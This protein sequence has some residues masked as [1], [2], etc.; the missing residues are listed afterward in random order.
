MPVLFVSHGA[1]T[2]AA[3]PEKGAAFRRLGAELPTPR[4]VLAISAHWERTPAATGTTQ[5]GHLLHDFAGF[6]RALYAL[7]Y[8]APGA[9]SLAA[10]VQALLGVTHDEA[11]PWDHGVWVPLL[12][13]LPLADVP[14]LQLALPSRSSPEDLFALGVRLAPLR[15]DGVLVLA[16]GGMVHDF[17]SI[18]R[19]DTTPPPTFALEFET[20][21]RETLTARDWPELLRFASRAPAFRRAHPSPEYFL[22]LLCAAGAA[23][24]GGGTIAFPIAGFELGSLSRLAVRFD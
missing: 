18:T 13:L 17:G 8:D 21:V 23:S 6:P 15:D 19:D 22:P 12:H 10:R 11:R 2:L 20:W 4:A 9:P 16:S 7:R 1:P 24:V 5:R 14:V 3:D